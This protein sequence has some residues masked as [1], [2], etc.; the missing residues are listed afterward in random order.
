MNLFVVLLLVVLVV[1]TVIAVIAE[2]YCSM[3][4]TRRSEGMVTSVKEDQTIKVQETL[5]A[6]GSV[7]TVRKIAC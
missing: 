5:P 4:E 7:G 2:V 3:A 6:N 1:L